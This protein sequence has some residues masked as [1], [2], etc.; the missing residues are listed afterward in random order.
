MSI[1]YSLRKGDEGQEVGRLQL[2]LGGLSIDGQFGNKTEHALK[3]YQHTNCLTSDGIAGPYTLSHMGNLVMPAVD[4]SRHNGTVDF[5]KLTASG[6][7][8]AWVKVTEGTTHINPG[9]EDKFKGCRD[10]GIA[11]GAYHFGRP[12]TNGGGLQDAHDEAKNFLDAVNKVGINCGDLLPV[13]DLEA[14][15]KTDDQLNVDWALAWLEEVS[16][17]TSVRPIIYTAKWY[18]NSYMRRASKSSLKEISKYPLWLAS[19][20]D[21]ID[22]ER[23]VPIWD[24]WHVWQ[25]TGTGAASGVKGNC[26]QNWIAGGKLSDLLVS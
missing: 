22:A 2:K 16:R 1:V 21:G 18:Y 11:V 9:Y 12:D 5:A 10:Y 19:Y 4:L 24:E 13:L 17:H 26:D 6:I 3:S 8:H 14:G 23:K 15:M 20:N 25:W 7:R